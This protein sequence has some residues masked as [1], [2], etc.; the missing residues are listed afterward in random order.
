[1]TKK[2]KR[3]SAQIRERILM[4]LREKP[5]VT[6]AQME[7]KINTGFRSIKASSEELVKYGLVEVRKIEKHPAN[8]RPAYFLSLT[9]QGQ[10]S[11]QR[12]IKQRS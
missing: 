8:G 6:Y 1:M 3:P 9:E 4:V 12:V 10:K 2:T 7:R 11:L 5:E